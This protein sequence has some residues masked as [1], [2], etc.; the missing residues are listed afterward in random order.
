MNW[1]N[2][3]MFSLA[4]NGKAALTIDN[5]MIEG[6][7]ALDFCNMKYD[8]RGLLGF[9]NGGEANADGAHCFRFATLYIKD[10]LTPS[11][12]VQSLYEKQ[13]ASEKEGYAKWTLKTK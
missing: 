13:S 10:G 12:Y 9:F 7:N 4:E 2:P 3:W 8:S 6:V 11:A 5:A 1:G